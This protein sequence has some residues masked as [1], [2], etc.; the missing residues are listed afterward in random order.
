MLKPAPKFKRFCCCERRAKYEASWRPQ[1]FLHDCK[2]NKSNESSNIS[3]HFLSEITVYST[4]ENKKICSFI[5]QRCAVFGGKWVQ[6]RFIKTVIAGNSTSCCGC[7]QVLGAYQNGTFRTEVVSGKSNNG[8]NLLSEFV[9]SSLDECYLLVDLGT[10][11]PLE[12]SHHLLT[13]LLVSPAA[14]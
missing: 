2:K 3:L 13:L 6:K 5:L 1:R 7:K 12:L 9:T 10:L 8:G 4:L 14:D 11:G